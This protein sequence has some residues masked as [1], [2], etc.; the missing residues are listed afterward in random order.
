M[1][2]GLQK[3]VSRGNFKGIHKGLFSGVAKG[4]GGLDPNNVE[5]KNR[6][7]MVF[8]GVNESARKSSMPTSI[9]NLTSWTICG[10]VKKKANPSVYASIIELTNTSL[11]RRGI[12]I[13]PT[14]FS[15]VVY[16]ADFFK[17]STTT[18]L[19]NT[20]W[21]FISASSNAT[22]YVNGILQSLGAETGAAQGTASVL[23]TGGTMAGS[24]FFNGNIDEA[25]V[26]SSI[27]TAAQV[28]E[29]YNEGQPG[30]LKKHSQVKNLVTWWRMGEN[31]SWNG[32][33][34]TVFDEIDNQSPGTSTNMEGSDVVSD[35]PQRK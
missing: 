21:Y 2:Q 13:W 29:I 1:K 25:S 3:G 27:L 34:F 5:F 10:W 24:Y 22:L 15:T 6:N 33:N 19:N 23:I 31:V 7:S 12:G 20:E 14:G 8:D 17:I 18:S 16:G 11:N 30:N 26:W 4:V 9:A 32:T 35:V 28:K